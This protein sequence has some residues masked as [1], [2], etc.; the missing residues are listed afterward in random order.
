M[1]GS[2]PTNDEPAPAPV[3]LTP[4]DRFEGIPASVSRGSTSEARFV[5]T[6]LHRIATESYEPIADVIETYLAGRELPASFQ[7]NEGAA[8]GFILETVGRQILSELYPGTS[9][10]HGAKL[11]DATGKEVG[12]LDGIV[13]DESG[14]VAALAEMKMS[15]GVVGKG[16]KK[17]A[18]LLAGI[19]DGT[20]THYVMQSGK[21]WSFGEAGPLSRERFLDIGPEACFGITVRESPP[22]PG[23]LRL[24]VSYRTIAKVASILTYYA[25]LNQT[26]PCLESQKYP[27]LHP[28]CA[29][30]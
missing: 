28:A 27:D 7:K 22:A 16:R 11:F 15:P 23:I 9:M 29:T 13:M 19:Q 18:S 20:L 24:S 30:G 21:R 10:M 12:E 5:E 14:Q 4:E 8:T 6:A 17:L 1:G 2:E 25:K 26:P 3:R